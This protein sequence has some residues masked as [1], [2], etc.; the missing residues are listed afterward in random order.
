MRGKRHNQTGRTMRARPKVFFLFA[1]GAVWIILAGPASGAR[2]KDIASFQGVRSNP[3]IGYGLVVGLEGTGDSPQSVFTNHSIA[4]VL[5]KLGVGV[6]QSVRSRNV[7]AVMVTSELPEF[8]RQGQRFDVTVSSM[9]DAK[10][11]QGGTL[12]LTPLRAVNGEIYALAQGPVSIGG[13]SA[14]ASGSKVAKNHQTV[15]RVVRGAV[16]E[17][18]INYEFESSEE[19]VL[20]L[21]D[22]DF[23]TALSIERE[24]NRTL[25]RGTAHAADPGTVRIEVGNKM[26]S[27]LVRYVA[28]IENLDVPVDGKARVI[29]NER[30]GTVVIGA[31]VKILPVAISH[32]GLKIQIKQT[33]QISQPL[34]FSPRG[35]TVVVPEAEVS[36]EEE[37]R[38]LVVLEQ[39]AT[40]DQLVSALNALGVSPRDLVAI[41]QALKAAGALQAEIQII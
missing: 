27:K 3:I 26:R 7:A 30:T 33:N 13:F 40:V 6:E 4:A 11:L 18:E 29:L 35:Q 14:G 28:A 25:G 19:L 8:P 41:F 24:I 34:P 23:T 2:I 10:S 15:G 38:N 37:T 22:P 20:I 17:K 31:D 9:G 5:D 32:G 36:V 39:N 21:D 1:L 16:V 12:V